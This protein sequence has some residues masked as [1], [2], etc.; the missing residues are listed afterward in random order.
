M[1]TGTDLTGPLSEHPF[2]AGISV[3]RVQ[4]LNAVAAAEVLPAGAVIF[5]EGEQASRLYVFEILPAPAAVVR[6]ARRQALELAPGYVL[7]GPAVIPLTPRARR[8]VGAS[9]GRPCMARAPAAAAV[10]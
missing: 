9:G 8:D 10:S 1:G 6:R 2:L 3:E 7:S 5:R 4:R